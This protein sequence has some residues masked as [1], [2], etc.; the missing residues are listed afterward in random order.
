MISTGGLARRGLETG[1]ALLQVPPVCDSLCSCFLGRLRQFQRRSTVLCSSRGKRQGREKIFKGEK[2][3]PQSVVAISIVLSLFKEEDATSNP[4]RRSDIASC[5]L[6]PFCD[7]SG[8]KKADFSFLLFNPFF[9]RFLQG[10][11]K[12]ELDGD[13]TGSFFFSLSSSV[14]AKEKCV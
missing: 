1:L 4:L 14:F 11:I 12:S 2:R 5:V 10:R 7:F 6:S 13:M 3:T 9:Q 8:R